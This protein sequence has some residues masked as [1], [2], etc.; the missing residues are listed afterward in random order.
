[1][2][3]MSRQDKILFAVLSLFLLAVFMI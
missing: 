1:M 3:R 2:N